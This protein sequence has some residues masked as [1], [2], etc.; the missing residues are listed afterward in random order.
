MSIRIQLICS[1]FDI[2]IVNITGLTAI[3][4]AVSNGTMLS[5]LNPF[6][7]SGPQ[8]APN[9]VVW[10]EQLQRLVLSGVAAPSPLAPPPV[11]PYQGG[12]LDA[13][14]ATLSLNLSQ[15][16]GTSVPVP[17]LNWYTF[18]GGPGS[19]FMSPVQKGLLSVDEPAGKVNSIIKDWRL[20]FIQIQF[21]FSSFGNLTYTTANALT[22][23]RL[24]T[25]LTGALAVLGQVTRVLVQPTN[26]LLIY[27]YPRMEASTPF[28]TGADM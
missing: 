21:F 14:V 2:P 10:S 9:E 17:S 11:Q 23:V 15:A 22:R 6:P 3:S 20:S 26:V 8:D 27:F 1:F 18:L 19:E 24:G 4:W 13:F 7:G 28:R 25:G 16:A 5:V 12:P